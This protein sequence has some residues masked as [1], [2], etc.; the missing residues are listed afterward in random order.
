MKKGTTY[1]SEVLKRQRDFYN[2]KYAQWPRLRSVDL[3]WQHVS[4]EIIKL[5]DIRK[6]KKYLYLGVG[7]GFIMEYIAQKTG[8]RIFGI[9]V[10]DYSLIYC[11]KKKGDGTFFINADAQRLPFKD[12]SFSGVIAPAVLHHLPDLKKA[13]TEFKRVLTDDKIIY[14]ID[15]RDYFLR[16][17]IN[18]FIARLISEDE[19]QLD[20]KKLETLYLESGFKI[21][22]SRPTYLFIP[23]IVPLFKRIRIDMPEKL[24]NFF[25]AIDTSLAKIRFLQSFSW[26]FTVVASL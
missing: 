20:Q 14:S 11:M 22:S 19:I 6:D 2:K 4:D 24:F 7:D 3:F 5:L 13:F 12:N 1:P 18:F 17:C 16:R 23:I 10:S 9:D 15:P 21:I 26:T 8:A 25:L